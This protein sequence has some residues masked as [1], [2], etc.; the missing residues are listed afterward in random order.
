VK[1]SNLDKHALA[2]KGFTLVMTLSILAAVTILVVGLFSI[3]SRERL[4]STSFDAVEQADLAVQ[5]GL[6]NA[7]ALLKEALK[8]ETT[9]IVSVPTA[10]WITLSDITADREKIL[11]PEEGKPESAT[12]MAVA[13]KVETAGLSSFA[14]TYIPLVSGVLSSETLPNQAA[15]PELAMLRPQPRPALPGTYL[16]GQPTFQHVPIKPPS[17]EQRLQLKRTMQHAAAHAPWQRTPSAFWVELKR[18]KGEFDLQ[19]GEG[20]VAARFSF[21]VEDLQGGLPLAT[22]GNFEPVTGLH[23]RTPFTFPPQA[24]DGMADR[25]RERLRWTAALVPGLN[26]RRPELSLLSETSLH[27]FFQPNVEPFA[28]S[29][30]LDDV[31]NRMHKVML[32]NHAM[33]FSPGS[34]KEVLLQPDPMVSWQGLQA[35]AVQERDTVTGSLTNP[36]MRRLEE[37]TAAGLMPYEELAL[38]PP[39]PA[40]ANLERYTNPADPLTFIEGPARKLNLNRVLREIETEE[41]MATRQEKARATV[42]QIATHIQNHLPHFAGTVTGTTNPDRAGRKGG[43][44]LPLGGDNQQKARAYLQCLAAGILDYADTDA[45][46][47]M[48]GEPLLKPE[49]DNGTKNGPQQWA[50]HYPRYRGVDAYPVVS[51][52][53]QRYRLEGNEAADGASYALYSVTHYLEIWNM[54]NQVLSGEIS[55][56]YEANAYIPAGFRNYDL[57]Q[58]LNGSQPGASIVSGRPLNASLAG[59]EGLTDLRRPSLK[60]SGWWH[61]PI[62]MDDPSAPDADL[63]SMPFIQ[64][65]QTP[66]TFKP[67]QPNEVRVLAFSP[68]V[69]RLNI[70]A[71]GGGSGNVTF[72]GYD[73]D[74]DMRS[75]YR[76]AFKPTGAPGFVV[77]DQPLQPV[78]RLNRGVTDSSKQRFNLGLP[79]LSYGRGGQYVNA[80]GDPRGAFFINFNQDFVNYENGSSPWARTVRENIKNREYGQTRVHLWPDGGH[81]SRGPHQ[82]AIIQNTNPDD[83][84]LVPAW[85]AAKIPNVAE[86]QKYVQHL[87]NTGRF[88]SVTELGHVFDPIMWDPNGGSPF[89]ASGAAPN[90]NFYREF[91][92]LLPGTGNNRPAIS[93]KFCGG[94]TLRI[95]RPEHE[96]FRADYNLPAA[97]GRPSLRSLS[98]TALLDLFHCGQPRS[99]WHNGELTAAEIQELTGDLVRIYGH[100]NLNTASRDTLRALAAGRLQMDPRL[101]RR[102]TTED[103][104]AT[105]AAP[106]FN[107]SILH[108]PSSAA[109]SAQAD[110]LAELIIRHR[111]YITPAELP[112]KVIM[113]TAMQIQQRPLPRDMSLE[114]NQPGVVLEEGQPVLGATRRATDRRVEP[115]WND[116][117]AEETFARIFNNATV[118]SRN[119][120]IVV[121]GQSLRRTRSGETKVLA[122][123]S[124]LYHVF[125]RPIRDANGN[126]IRQQT[127]ITYARTL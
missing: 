96:R 62:R 68:V 39:D 111:P 35:S 86:R 102:M 24:P 104:D 17:D 41:N 26:L 56:A 90:N 16:N 50:D 9:L 115:E 3:V 54:T 83:K 32:R 14:W 70:G 87:S 114:T 21:Y 94:N 52:H 19:D 48:D 45:L 18:P 108:P 77:V 61:Q 118:R 127:E 23:E 88:F 72:T 67:M 37:Q 74:S 120:K 117:A 75:R 98:A 112:E 33:H 59:G 38:I 99:G 76:I 44:P 31:L 58:C 47:T 81:I 42:D 126:I 89:S 97:P 20:E 53:W 119:F 29:D 101:R 7:G 113:P 28:G 25:D 124:R 93:D 100:V 55:A 5:A 103:E 80:F 13:R 84:S 66:P 79:G 34:W 4:T 69:Y 15:N 60:L 57:M 46:P 106:T 109:N 116:A 11:Q 10:P 40:F 110:L 71:S 30:R 1:Q 43:Y 105:A 125:V 22:A 92:N 91:A 63:R 78:D 121:T 107:E 51:K 27:T 6:E 123:R 8:D 73:T 12:L 95:G 122:T 2:G 65:G 82:A 49:E 36:V 64:R 85:H